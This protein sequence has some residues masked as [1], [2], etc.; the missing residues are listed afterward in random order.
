MFKYINVALI[1]RYFNREEWATPDEKWWPEREIGTFIDVLADFTPALT[2]DEIKDLFN[3][4][5]YEWPDDCPI[6][7]KLRKILLDK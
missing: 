2:E 3:L 6:T 5:E 4:L 1:G 7:I